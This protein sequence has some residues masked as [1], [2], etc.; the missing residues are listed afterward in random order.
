MAASKT[1]ATVRRPLRTFRRLWTMWSG[2][3]RWVRFL[4]VAV[5]IAI[6]IAVFL[7]PIPAVEDSRTWVRSTGAWGP[8]TYLALMVGFTQLP[9][10][11]TVWT[12]TAGVVFGSVLGSALALVGLTISAAISLVLVRWLGKGFIARST[13]GDGRL[14]LLQKVVA[15]RGWVAA[16]GLRMVP[17]VPFSILNYA[18]A[19]STL[20]VV[21]FLAATLVGS[22]PNTIATV[23]ASSAVATG[24]S[25]LVLLLSVAVVGLGFAIS[26]REFFQWRQ[27][28]S[29]L[30]TTDERAVD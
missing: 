25:P 1:D 7:I 11:R 8:L 30:R 19:L 15:E 27:Q 9:L 6:V 21:P 18:C 29:R 14:A 20:R 12:I 17:A 5:P 24:Q 13:A 2:W 10:P 16:L 22:A 3:S 4:S 23:I 26:A 28:L